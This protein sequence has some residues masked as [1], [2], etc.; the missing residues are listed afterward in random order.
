MTPN[1]SNDIRRE[2]VPPPRTPGE[3]DPVEADLVE[4]EE[5]W[6]GEKMPLGR[7]LAALAAAL[8]LP[9]A[10][11]LVLGRRGRALL[12]F[13]LVAVSLVCGVLLHGKLFEPVEGQPL[14]Y[15]GTFGAMGMGLAYFVLRFA[16]GYEGVVEAAGYEYGTAFLV[17]AGLMNLLLV[18][19]V[20]DIARGGKE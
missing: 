6:V 10:G 19:D 2:T 7:T 11:H 8:V 18:L 5:E 20:W 3:A 16:L 14:T 12:F 9:G 17:T 1:A 15:L 4:A 13:V